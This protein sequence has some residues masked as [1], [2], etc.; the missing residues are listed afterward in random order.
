MDEF[1]QKGGDMMMKLRQMIDD[2]QS[3]TLTE[4]NIDEWERD[5]AFMRQSVETT[6]ENAYVDYSENRQAFIDLLEEEDIKSHMKENIIPREVYDKLYNTQRKMKEIFT[7]NFF[8]SELIQITNEKMF[9][10]IAGIDAMQIRESVL[11]ETRETDKM[12]NEMAHN[13]LTSHA[14]NQQKLMADTITSVVR[15][16]NN[17]MEKMF[18][19]FQKMVDGLNRMYIDNIR[20]LDRNMQDNVY[21]ALD[22]FNAEVTPKPLATQEQTAK[23]LT[24]E[25]KT[26]VVTN[27]EN[28]KQELV[29]LNDI[30]EDED[31]E[32]SESDRRYYDA[33]R[34]LDEKRRKNAHADSQK[35]S[36]ILNDKKYLADNIDVISPSEMGLGNDEDFDKPYGDI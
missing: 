9:K 7:W 21:Q 12:R 20:H 1:S 27:T 28:K 34:R 22:K 3:R 18:D 24:E 14:S 16:Q 33:K 29:N 30:P 32:M 15:E 36:D 4:D 13:I 26:F 11:R 5:L 17:G 2:L 25:P 19:R 10:L 6:T 23:D 8:Y 35:N 31:E